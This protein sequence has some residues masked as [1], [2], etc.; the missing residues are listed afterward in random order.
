MIARSVVQNGA[1]IVGYGHSGGLQARFAGF[2]AAQRTAAGKA[3]WFSDGNIVNSVVEGNRSFSWSI[4]YGIT[5]DTCSYNTAN[6]NPCF[7]LSA[8]A[9]TDRPGNDIA[10]L[11]APAAAP[12]KKLNS[13]YSVFTALNA[14]TLLNP[15]D[16]TGDAGTNNRAGDVSAPTIDFSSAY[17]NG[18]NNAL[19]QLLYSLEQSIV[20]G[21]PVLEVQE[22]ITAT[23][24]STAA[25]F[26]EGGNFIDVRFG[27]LTR[28]AVTAGNWLDFG[29]Y[30][31]TTAAV[32]AT[33][34]FATGLSTVTTTWPKLGTDRNGNPRSSANFIRGALAQ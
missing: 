34:N 6:G 30:N 8:A 7:G 27:P 16:G 10:V 31:P 19:K 25:A 1:G 18:P 15:G 12:V 21:A 26:D 20:I 5:Q 4:N 24:A 17:L 2:T 3:R 23:V 9:A 22:P 29:T 32:S 33:G 11:F 28:G 13:S 14:G